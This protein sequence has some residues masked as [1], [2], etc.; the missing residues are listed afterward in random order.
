MRA[1]PDP[2]PAA[3]VED[4]SAAASVSGGDGVPGG[5]A[6][7]AKGA[8]TLLVP[9]VSLPKQHTPAAAAVGL[10]RRPEPHAGAGAAE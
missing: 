8:E 7:A 1:D 6:A 9:G 5:V 2:R 3:A 4:G 10:R